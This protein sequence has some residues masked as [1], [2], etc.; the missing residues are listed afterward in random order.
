MLKIYLFLLLLLS[1][2]T[3]SQNIWG[4]GA[5]QGT[6]PAQFQNNFIETGATIGFTY[7]EWHALS[8]Y[9][10]GNTNTPGTAYWKRS[11]IGYSQGTNNT[12]TTPINSPSQANGVAIFD[13]DY[14]G[15]NG[16]PSI[17]KGELISP[18]LDLTGNT[19]VPIGIR[20]YSSYSASQINELSVSFSND[21]GFSWLPANDYRNLQTNNTEGF[22][23]FPFPLN[24][25]SG[26]SNLSQ[27]RIK[28]T[29]EGENFFAM[30]DDITILQASALSSTDFTTK[31]NISLYPN[32]TSNT[33]SIS[34]EDED[35]NNSFLQIFDLKGREILLKQLLNNQSVIDISKF[36]FGIYLFKINS[37]NKE[38]I[39]KVVK[40]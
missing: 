34:I 31:P 27:C 17:H 20:F 21:G 19:N 33:V 2:Q 18:L 38:I 12:N 22:V 23:E 8:V 36:D 25:T 28:F 3:Y 4:L 11:T 5:T 29:F 10:T 16:S 24:A 6:S 37:Q 15:S 9:D 1:F 30:V 14:L 13:S 39:Y 32:P 40:Q 7:T 26:L 35:E